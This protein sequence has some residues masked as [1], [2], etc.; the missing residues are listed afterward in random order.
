MVRLPKLAEALEQ[1]PA[2]A[3]LHVNFDHLT[4][5]DHAC[6]DLLIG[7]EKQHAT[8]GGSL[9]IDWAALQARFSDG[10]PRGVRAA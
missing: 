2:S 4:Y 7:W 1:V 9:T 6:L 8:S 5:I 10:R 3:E